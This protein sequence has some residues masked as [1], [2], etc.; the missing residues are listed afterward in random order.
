[1]TKKIKGRSRPVVVSVVHLGHPHLFLCFSSP[2]R[3]SFL[4]FCKKKKIIN[5]DDVVQFSYNE[6][7]YRLEVSDVVLAE[8]LH[9]PLF[10]A[11]T[12]AIYSKYFIVQR[13]IK[14]IFSVPAYCQNLNILNRRKTT[15]ENHF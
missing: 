4:K 5:E 12:L 2:D 1:M 11:Y 8:P 3:P 6:Y 10:G 13:D 14:S 15:I 7:H 9:V